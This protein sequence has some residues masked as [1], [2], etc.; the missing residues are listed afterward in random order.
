MTNDNLEAFML[1]SIEKSIL[2][3]PDNDIISNDLGIK[4]LISI[5]FVL[6]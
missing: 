4:S 3:E 2:M 5:S 1:M 6:Y